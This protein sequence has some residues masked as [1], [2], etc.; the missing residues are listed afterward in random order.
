MQFLGDFQGSNL[1]QLIVFTAPINVRCDVHPTQEVVYDLIYK[2]YT[3]HIQAIYK[4]YS[5]GSSIYSTWGITFIGFTLVAGP[6]IAPRHAMRRRHRLDLSNL[7]VSN[8]HISIRVKITT[9]PKD[10]LRWLMI[11]GGKFRIYISDNFIRVYLCGRL[12]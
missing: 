8:G 12:L 10:C 4:P 2:P 5:W 11:E 1:P 6:S 3:S 7:A 9:A